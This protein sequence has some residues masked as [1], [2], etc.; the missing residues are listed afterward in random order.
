[1]RVKPLPT[2]ETMRNIVA[3]IPPEPLYF[4]C[5]HPKMLKMWTISKSLLRFFDR[6]T[7]LPKI[8][9]S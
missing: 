3:T 9:H 1:M 8:T 4:G 5:N 2:G 7:V 6:L